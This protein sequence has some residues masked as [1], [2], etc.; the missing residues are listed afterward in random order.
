MNRGEGT[1]PH[2]P[3]PGPPVS[4]RCTCPPTSLSSPLLSALPALPV[5]HALTT[6]H[7]RQ[8]VAVALFLT[9]AMCATVVTAGRG[10][11]GTSQDAHAFAGRPHA[12]YAPAQPPTTATRCHKPPPRTAHGCCSAHRYYGLLRVLRGPLL[13]AVNKKHAHLLHNVCTWIATQPVTRQ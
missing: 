4:C 9:P 3:C 1:P 11:A 10:W 2:C 8:P 5:L 7:E 12:T 6:P 13:I